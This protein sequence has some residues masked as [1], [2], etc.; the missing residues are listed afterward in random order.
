MVKPYE[1]LDSATEPAPRLKQQVLGAR[2]KQLRQAKKQYGRSKVPGSSKG[3]N[4][5]VRIESQNKDL[6]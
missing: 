3:G 5:N 1:V 4:P 2:P 6:G